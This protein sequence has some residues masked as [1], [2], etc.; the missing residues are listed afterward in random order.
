MRTARFV[1]VVV[2]TVLVVGGY[3]ASQVAYFNGTATEYAAKVDTPS[4]R[5][6]SLLL[7]LVSIAMAFVR[8]PEEPSS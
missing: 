7:L 8:E 4:I 3:A 1:V 6:L 2:L 5:I